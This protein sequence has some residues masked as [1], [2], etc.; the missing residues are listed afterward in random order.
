MNT[1]RTQVYAR[2]KFNYDLSS[3]RV[4]DVKIW[5]NNKNPVVICRIIMIY[6]R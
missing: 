1:T 2:T 6:Y 5:S 3:T 4:V